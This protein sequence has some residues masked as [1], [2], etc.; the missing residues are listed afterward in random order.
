MH[1]SSVPLSSFCLFNKL[2]LLLWLLFAK[3]PQQVWLAVYVV[4]L[5]TNSCNGI[6]N[7][8][9]CRGERSDNLKGIEK[10]C[11]CSSFIFQNGCLW[12]SWALGHGRWNSIPVYNW[13]PDQEFPTKGYMH[14]I[15]AWSGLIRYFLA[16]L[17]KPPTFPAE[18]GS[19][20]QRSTALAR[21]YSCPIHLY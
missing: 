2:T 9:K 6:R 18:A 4:V 19:K 8:L 13:P 10:H 3:F 1:P 11:S 7:P 16:L 14:V 21:T 12:E 15:I 17:S 5:A 20:E